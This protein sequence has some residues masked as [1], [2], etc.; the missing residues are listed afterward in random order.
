MEFLVKV[1]PWLHQSLYVTVLYFTDQKPL[2]GFVNKKRCYHLLPLVK[3]G[4]LVI[5]LTFRAYRGRCVYMAYS[6][7]N[8]HQYRAFQKTVGELFKIIFLNVF[9]NFLSILDFLKINF[10]QI[11]F[12]HTFEICIYCKLGN[13]L[14]K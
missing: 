11:K 2:V 13:L 1:W 10:K 4:T 3:G 8:P 9:T 6:T 12:S 14:N 7:S 5:I